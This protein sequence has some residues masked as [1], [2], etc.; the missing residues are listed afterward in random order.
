MS[1]VGPIIRRWALPLAAALALLA[2][3][4]VLSSIGVD[5]P[6][7]GFAAVVETLALAA[8]IALAYPLAALGFGRLMHAAIPA[9][10]PPAPHAS[11]IQFV[12][13]VAIM[14]TLS[15]L[16]GVLGALRLGSSGAVWLAWSPVMLGLVLLALQVRARPVSGQ[17]LA[18][19]PFTSL[20]IVPP[21]ALLVVAACQPPGTLWHSE[22]RAF[23]TLSYH[24][25]LPKEWLAR[26]RITPLEHNVYSFL[27]S[28]IESAYTHLGAMVGGPPN[29]PA[30]A[31]GFGTFAAHF[32][33]AGL[34]LGAALLVARLVRALAARRDADDRARAA[35]RHASVIAA[36]VFLALPWTIVV[37]SLA[38]NEMGVLLLFAGAL[39]VS[40]V[41]TLPP[42]ARAS[43]CGVL[44]GAACSC[45]P[46]AIFTAALPVGVAL[47]ITA[48]PRRWGA[49][50][51]VGSTAALLVM[52]PWLTRNHIS[53][54]NGLFPFATDWLGRA[55]W[56][57]EQTQR[58]HE[59]HHSNATVVDRFMLLCSA[60]R[61][62]LHPQWSIFPW[63][64]LVALVIALLH[65]ATHRA[66]AVL[67]VILLIQLGAWLGVGHLQARFLIPIAVPGSAAIGLAIVALGSRE[68]WRMPAISLGSV[69]ALA[70]AGWSGAIFASQN[71]GNP[72]LALLGGVSL[73]NGSLQRQELPK[74]PPAEQEQVMGQQPP[75][76]YVNLML[77]RLAGERKL[78]YL[79]GD[80]T[81]YYLN[82][83]VLWGTTWD[84]SL[85]AEALSASNNDP[86]AAADALRAQGVTH[87]LVNMNELGRL[88]ESKYLDPRLT[89][90]LVAEFIAS[91][92]KLLA[93]WTNDGRS[94]FL[95]ELTVPAATQPT[96]A[97]AP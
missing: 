92:T 42:V 45:K 38:Y 73:L 37:G 52:L 25:Q 39:L 4:G 63:L 12:G 41:P 69:G 64:V 91:Q 82:V 50:T 53:C 40:A 32:L 58:F 51:L 30:S 19:A 66:A 15:H 14:L 60:D 36:A 61:G 33:H 13:G 96:P 86:R 54:G 26:S 18:T 17:R 27:P 97:S 35:M 90:E 29:S 76:V 84:R 47:L 79:L 81:P 56:S 87:I 49:M 95:V 11:S 43:I 44:M 6:L 23:D 28:Y 62:L 21:I 20:L 5:L 9:T 78:L 72:N 68:R 88:K 70:L 31:R 85:L 7:A 16:L 94:Q 10:A 83:P 24:L 48:P 59:A 22:A 77:P 80:S 55:H 1:A 34:A 65:R 8:P 46:T 3:V 71:S 89:P 75:E 74:L 2:L 67:A 57:A 93:A